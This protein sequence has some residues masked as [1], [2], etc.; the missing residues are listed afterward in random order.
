M[1]V[2]DTKK[3]Y[4]GL[5]AACIFAGSTLASAAADFSYNALLPVYLK[6]DRTLMPDDIVDGY[7]ETYRPEVWSRFRDDEFELQE[8]RE[9]TLQIMKDAIAAA[10]P[11]EVFTIQTRF[12]FGDYNFESEK[13]DFQ[14]LGEGLYFN[15]DQCC[16]SLPRQLKVFFANPKIIDGIP[17]EKAKAKAFLN[18]RKSSYGTVDRVVLAKVNI[19]M[20]EVRSRGEMVAEIQEMQLY[21]RE[22]R[23][24]IMKLDGAQATAVSQ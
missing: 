23:S 22:G 19:R 20:K 11:D 7:M 14:P 15:V 16:T 13:F 17:M 8:K 2:F 12:E 21:D 6:L 10:N 5:A 18:A 3:I 1:T 24:L 4:I 9:E